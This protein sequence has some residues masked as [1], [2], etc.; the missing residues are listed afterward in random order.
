MPDQRSKWR[1]GVQSGPY[2]EE[3]RCKG[4]RGSGINVQRNF[5]SAWC[6]RATRRYV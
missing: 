1:V 4:E 3:P 5:V 6:E 2:K